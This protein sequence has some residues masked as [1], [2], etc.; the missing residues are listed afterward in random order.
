MIQIGTY[1]PDGDRWQ[2][3]L[4]EQQGKW[5]CSVTDSQGRMLSYICDKHSHLTLWDIL[6]LLDQRQKRFDKN[7]TVKIDGKPIK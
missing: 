4:C 1:K 2:C 6:S 3:A 7:M 5:L